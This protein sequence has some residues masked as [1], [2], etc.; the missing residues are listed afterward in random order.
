MVTPATCPTC[1]SSTIWSRQKAETELLQGRRSGVLRL[2]LNQSALDTSSESQTF[3]LAGYFPVLAVDVLHGE[4][5]LA[6]HLANV[7]DTTNSRPCHRAP[8]ERRCDI[9]RRELCRERIRR[10]V[11]GAN[12]GEVAWG[13]RGS[14]RLQSGRVEHCSGTPA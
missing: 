4:E 7:V 6:V 2:R 8:A 11:A 13:S 14:I 3:F 1:S 5:V 12:L 9:V 10:F